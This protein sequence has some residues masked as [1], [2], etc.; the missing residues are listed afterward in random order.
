MCAIAIHVC[1]RVPSIKGTYSAAA[2]VLQEIQLNK[3][4][5]A[6]YTRIQNHVYNITLIVRDDLQCNYVLLGFLLMLFTHVA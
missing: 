4:H 6:P 1:E 5:D 2:M 3:E